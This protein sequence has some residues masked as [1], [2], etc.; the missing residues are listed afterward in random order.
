[1]I[2]KL[3][4]AC[5]FIAF[6]TG[7]A[8]AQSAPAQPR[9]S[10]VTATVT[11]VIKQ[12]TKIVNGSSNYFQDIKVRI[13]SGPEKG[14]VIEVENGLQNKITKSELYT[15]GQEIVL[16][17][18]VNSNGQTEYSPYDFYRINFLIIFVVIFF[19]LIFA[20]AGF[21]G[22]GSIAGMLVSLA[23]IMLYIVPTILKGHNPLST[24]I[25]GSAFII[26]LSTYLAH[27]VSKKSTIA[28]FS[29][30]ISIVLAGVFANLAMHFGN[31]TGLGNEDYVNLQIGPTSDINIQGLFLSAIIIGT[32]GALNDITTTQSATLEEFKETNPKLKA[33]ELFD[34]GLKVGREH[35]ASLINTL[36]LAYVGSA[37][38]VLIFFVLNPLH[39][40]YWV[41]LNNEIIADE[42]VKII[43][44]SIGLLLSVPI[45]TFLGSLFYGKVED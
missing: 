1:M 37:F 9:T 8:Y 43:A 20:V 44:G 17:K 34:K 42:V 18:T 10:Y 12:G 33:E 39:V 15:K 36:V 30:L 25:I 24:T 41:I 22:L 6:F 29:T 28:L 5:F 40:P 35:I 23:I 32:L 11:Y 7:T 2:K 3:L 21:K 31:I 19:I 4:L 27:G 38:A 13:D 26:I 45:V 14:K 16:S